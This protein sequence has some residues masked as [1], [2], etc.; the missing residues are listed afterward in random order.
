MRQ[1]FSLPV[2]VL[3]FLQV[4][5]ATDPTYQPKAVS[6]QD[7]AVI[8]TT[9][10]GPHNPFKLCDV[11][12][13]WIMK[14]DGIRAM[15]WSPS[16]LYQFQIVD[17]GERTIAVS[18]TIAADIAAVSIYSAEA[19]LSATFKTGHTYLIH[20]EWLLPVMSFWIEDKS[21]GEIVSEKQSVNAEHHMQWMNLIPRK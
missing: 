17:P 12:D 21:T 5:C 2:M 14:V 7:G 6:E 20:G 4:G 18:G 8:R 3:L 16:H 1:L 15:P 11:P 13:V 9:W 10:C 19:E